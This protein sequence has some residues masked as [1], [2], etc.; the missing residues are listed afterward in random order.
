MR[1]DSD[2]AKHAPLGTGELGEIG[3]VSPPG[4]GLARV[5]LVENV[6]H[7]LAVVRAGLFIRARSI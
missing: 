5:Q 1:H 3:H 6:E 7:R 4:R 2:A